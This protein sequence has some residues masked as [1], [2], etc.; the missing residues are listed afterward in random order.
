MA[1]D[2]H[3]TTDTNPDPT[4][5]KNLRWQLPIAAGNGVE[6]WLA[7]KENAETGEYD[8]VFSFKK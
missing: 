2:V 3:P 8:V 5:R 4:V 6:G 7:V 1:Y